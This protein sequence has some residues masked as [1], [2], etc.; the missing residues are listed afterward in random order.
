MRLFLLVLVASCLAAP[1]RAEA[2][3]Y[4][5]GP[6][7]VIQV[8]VL[9]QPGMSGDFTVDPEGLINFPFVGSVKV[10]DT[11]T[12]GVERKLTTLLS[13]GYLKKPQVS[14][15]VKLFRSQRVFVLGEVLRPGPYGLRPARSLLALLEDVGELTPSAGHEVAVVRVPVPEPVEGEP[16]QPRKLRPVLPGENPDAE[17]YRVTLRQLRSGDPD[18]DMQLEIGDTVYIPKAAQ[19]YITGHVARPGAFRFEEGMT[20]VQALNLAGGVT[21]RGSKKVKITRTVAGKL[22]DVRPQLT[23]SLLPEDSIT[24]PER[25]F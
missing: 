11:T 9:G 4:E 5:V 21:E 10:S 25:F 1:L 7:D 3:A 20:V 15:H 6:A 19:I 13:D 16:P 17:V 12:A 8:L 2:P 18:K 23:D 22:Q 14:V 24:V